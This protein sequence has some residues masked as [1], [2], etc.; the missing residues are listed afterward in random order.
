[1][2]A[3]TAVL[4]TFSSF[5]EWIRDANSCSAQAHSL[6]WLVVCLKKYSLVVRGNVVCGFVR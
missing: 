1:V 4:V 5:R 2:V 6:H 3:V